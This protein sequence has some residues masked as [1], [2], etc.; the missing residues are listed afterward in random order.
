[1]DFKFK[2]GLPVWTSNSDS[3]FGLPFR[4]PNLD[5][6]FGLQFGLPFWTSNSEFQFGLPV[7]TSDSHFQFELPIRTY[8]VTITTLQSVSASQ[9][10]QRHHKHHNHN[11]HHHNHNNRAG[12]RALKTQVRHESA[13][14]RRR[15]GLPAYYWSRSHRNWSQYSQRPSHIGPL[16][17]INDVM[18]EWSNWSSWGRCSRSCGGGV[19]SRT[20]SCVTSYP[21][22]MPGSGVRTSHDRCAGESAEYGVCGA[23]TCPPGQVSALSFRAAQC[24]RYNNRSVFGRI[25]NNWIPYTQGGINP[26]ALV[27]EGEGE[28]I[29]YTFGKVTDGTHCKTTEEEGAREGLCVNGRCL[30]V[31]CDGRLGGGALED[32]CRVCGGHNE[33]CTRHSGVFHTDRPAADQ[34]PKAAALTSSSSSSSSTAG[35]LRSGS[36]D[37]QQQQQT[38][39]SLGYHEVALIPRGATNVKATDH[40]ANFLALRAGNKYILN[41]DWLIDWPGDVDAG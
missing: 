6:L 22:V 11:H 13:S 15:G 37:Q 32:M 26:C 41:G 17:H 31:S 40:S 9:D 7:P 21:R 28:G 10:H 36:Q 38:P 34:P 2:F 27:C 14:S 39:Q 29:V 35:L 4:T 20:R 16:P 18:S 19:R 24:R 8:N 1:M 30:R 33:T 3:Q 23:A 12:T 5:I 25:V